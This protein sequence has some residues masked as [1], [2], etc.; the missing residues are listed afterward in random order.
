MTAPGPRTMR[1]LD[2]I[3]LLV[4]SPR[5]RQ[6]LRDLTG[7][8]E[9]AI[10][11]WVRGMLDEGLIEVAGHHRREGSHKES[12]VLRWVAWPQEAPRADAD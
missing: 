5:T 7:L 12:E 8:S 1:L 6:E 3:S 4:K 11:V 10:L 9:S 2:M